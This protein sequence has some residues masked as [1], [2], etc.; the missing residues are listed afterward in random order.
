MK[1]EENKT[2]GVSSREQHIEEENAIR[3]KGL[4]T[5][6]KLNGETMREKKRVT[7]NDNYERWKIHCRTRSYKNYNNRTPNVSTAD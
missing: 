1:P 5:N 6:G 3:L 4:V 2:M 7:R